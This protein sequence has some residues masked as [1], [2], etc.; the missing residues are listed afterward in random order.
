MILNTNEF[1]NTETKQLTGSLNMCPTVN[2][3]YYFLLEIVAQ[4]TCSQMTYQFHSLDIGKL[5]YFLIVFANSSINKKQD[6]L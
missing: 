4:I 3:K 5:K 1:F 6:H 2:S